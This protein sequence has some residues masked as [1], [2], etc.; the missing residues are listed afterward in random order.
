MKRSEVTSAFD[1]TQTQLD[2]AQGATTYINTQLDQNVAEDALV[3]D[4]VTRGYTADN[5]QALVNEV[6]RT[7]FEQS[8]LARITDAR[9][10]AAYVPFGAGPVG[11][12]ED[13]VTYPDYGPPGMGA[14]QPQAQQPQA[15]QPYPQPAAAYQP[16]TNQPVYEA[17]RF[18]PFSRADAAPIAGGP[19]VELDQFGQP[20]LSFGPSG[21]PLGSYVTMPTSAGPFDPYQMEMPE[22]PAFDPQQPVVRPPFPQQPQPV[23]NQGIGGLGRK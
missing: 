3:A 6:Q 7:R 18:A 14:V 12:E 1:I 5:A 23:I 19:A 10:S 22:A 8:E 16:P 4:L 17:P 2:F 20:I 21:R 13:E 15:Q 11:G 9:R